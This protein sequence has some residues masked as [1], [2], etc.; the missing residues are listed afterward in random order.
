[1]LWIFWF[2][3]LCLYTGWLMLDEVYEVD[4]QGIQGLLLIVRTTGNVS[5]VLF[6]TLCNFLMDR[7]VFR[8]L[9]L[10]VFRSYKQSFRNRIYFFI[11]LGIGYEIGGWIIES[12][13]KNTR[14]NRQIHLYNLHKIQWELP[15]F[16]AFV[17]NSACRISKW[18]RQSVCPYTCSP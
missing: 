1:M 18:K 11:R 14:G 4:H 5:I 3:Q 13:Y 2:T 16:P 8:K 9:Q 7:P 12:S 17:V 6:G 10:I 15:Y